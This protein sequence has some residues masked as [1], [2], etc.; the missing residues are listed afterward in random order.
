MLKIFG[1]IPTTRYL[2]ALPLTLAALISAQAHAGEF[3]ISPIRI[4]MNPEDRAVAVTITNESE[5]PLVM[6][7]DLYT[8]SQDA[9]GK[10]VLELSD[11]L[12]LSPPI[13]KLEPKG[14]QVVRLA[15]LTNA[16][17][18]EQLTFRMIAREI[19]EARLPAA[20]AQVQVALALSLPIF[21]TPH[22][23][24]SELECSFEQA[25]APQV[26]CENLG[27]AYAQPRALT[28]S[29][30]AGETVAT[31]EPASYILPGI[32]LAYD[33]PADSVAAT[34]AERLQV[35][36]DDNSQVMFDIAPE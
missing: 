11:E 2:P 29:N 34:G 22:N 1:A 32:K 10:E 15:R 3:T 20:G 28:L 16:A 26:I 7:A 9:T 13:I 14:R 25:T 4:Y 6:Q 21:I 24:K 19:P 33:L 36:L 35:T 27:N 30:A 17:P 23:A 5:E 8:W 18:T 31:L 12:F